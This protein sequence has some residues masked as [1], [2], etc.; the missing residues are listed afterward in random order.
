MQL[1]DSATAAVDITLTGPL[2]ETVPVG[3]LEFR[4]LNAEIPSGPLA[5]SRA[6]VSFIPE[7]PRV[8]V[9]DLWGSA[10]VRGYQVAVTV[11]G[12]LGQQQIKLESVPESLPPEIAL[13]LGAGIDPE[14]SATETKLTIEPAGKTEELP[15]P[16]IGCTWQID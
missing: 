16:Q 9:L 5:F 14:K 15:P 4:G 13:L 6:K 7:S 1:G 2:R 8:P 11:W 3:V 10:Q 12:P